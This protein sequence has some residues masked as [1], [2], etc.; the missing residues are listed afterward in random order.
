MTSSK[1]NVKEAISLVLVVAVAHSLLSLPKNLLEEQK[2]AVIL[3]IIYVSI[4]AILFSYLVYKLFKSFPGKDIIDISE[5]LGGKSLKNILGILFISYLAF[6]GSILLRNFCESIK[7]VY[8]PNTRVAFIIAMFIAAIIIVCSLD[9]KSNIK[10]TFI[11]MPIV[12]LSMVFLFICNL[13]N[14]ST[15]RMFPILG[16]GFT[17]TFITGIGNLYAFSGIVFLYFLP[18]LLKNP[19]KFK[20]IS[21]ISISISAVYIIM[22]VS[23]ILFMFAYFVNIDEI[24]PLFS[25][26][27]YIEFGSFFQ[28]LESI[29][30]LIWFIIF[31]CY[32][33]ITMMYCT[34]IFKKI[35]NLKD[36]KP[37]VPFFGLLFLAIALMPK[38]YA[39]SS[40]LETTAYPILTIG[41]T[42]I[43]SG[44]LLLLANIKFVKQKGR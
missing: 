37:I 31:A 7:I 18:P 10:T 19:S 26:A 2:S 36:S 29:F 22:T 13:K 16:D 43:L 23:I 9:F 44:L 6:S 11:I 12:L 4:L 28:R 5:F 34:E 1:F 33:S 42:F 21:L 38:N 30:L 41:I 17:N 3:N 39:S 14:F 32:L 27:R 15:D 24:M 8:F 35:T 40:F 25:A 20:K